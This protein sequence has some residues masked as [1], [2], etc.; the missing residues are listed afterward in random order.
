MPGSQTTPGRLRTRDIARSR[1]A[2]RKS[3]SVGAQN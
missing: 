3:D 1:V 2:F